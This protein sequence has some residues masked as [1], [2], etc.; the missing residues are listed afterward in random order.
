MTTFCRGTGQKDISSIAPLAKLSPK[1][2]TS[3]RKI[4]QIFLDRKASQRRAGVGVPA[5][6]PLRRPR[7]L[8]VDG[9]QRGRRRFI[10]SLQL[11][12]HVANLGDARAYWQQGAGLFPCS[13]ASSKNHQPCIG[14]GVPAPDRSGAASIFAPEVQM[15][16]LGSRS[17]S[18]TISQYL[19][20]CACPCRDRPSGAR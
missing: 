12:Y 14:G 2:R 11:F 3:L 20:K 7:R 10:D 17:F 15:R 4:N 19:P 13:A 1:K 9:R 8:R 16:W 5:P 18:V 6:G